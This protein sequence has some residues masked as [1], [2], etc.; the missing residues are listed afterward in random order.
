MSLEG[1]KVQ[2]LRL[3]FLAWKRSVLRQ[4]MSSSSPLIPASGLRRAFRDP[5][6]FQNPRGLDRMV[7]LRR[8]RWG[9]WRSTWPPIRRT[10]CRCSRGLRPR[11]RRRPGR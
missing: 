10:S 1:F 7:I 5:R 8:G 6:D 9:S 3:A 2:G 4:E 11:R